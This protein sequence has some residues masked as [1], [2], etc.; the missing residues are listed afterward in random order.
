MSDEI[1]GSSSQLDNH[2]CNE[3]DEIFAMSTMFD[4]DHAPDDEDHIHVYKATSDPD[5]QYHDEAMRVHDAKMFRE[6]MTTEWTIQAMNK[7]FS[8]MKKSE[9]KYL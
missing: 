4:V 1:D 5:T 7:N 9:P 8:L 6:A 2:V 3:A